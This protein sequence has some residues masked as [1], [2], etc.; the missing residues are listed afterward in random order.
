MLR[1]FLSIK[2]IEIAE[3]LIEAVHRGKVFVAVPL[4]I[5]AELAGGVAETLHDGGH[6]DVGLLPSFRSAGHADLCHAGADRNGTIDEGSA[7]SGTTLLAVVIGEEDAL[8]SDTVDVWRLEPHHAAVLVAAMLDADI[9]TP[10]YEDVRFLCG[11]SLHTCWLDRRVDG[12][13]HRN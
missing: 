13:H 8:V 6:R 9:I 10:D 12:A 4:V 7:A 3:E 1:L 5:L 2:V 11:L